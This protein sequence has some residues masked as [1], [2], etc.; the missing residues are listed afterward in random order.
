MAHERRILPES[1][2]LYVKRVETKT[3]TS[4]RILTVQASGRWP[5]EVYQLLPTVS[6][7]GEAPT[8]APAPRSCPQPIVETLRNFK[9]K[10][11]PNRLLLTDG[12]RI[13][14]SLA[15][16]IIYDRSF[17][18]QTEPRRDRQLPTSVRALID[19]QIDSSPHITRVR[20][21]IVT[22]HVTPQD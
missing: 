4:N 7:S 10:G 11:N 13:A 12:M 22:R 8:N 17:R 16:I 21:E 15:W 19:A 3:C 5:N 2:S 1:R 6:R 14:L 18:Y 20:L 9:S